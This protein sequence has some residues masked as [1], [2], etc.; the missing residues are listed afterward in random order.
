M[1]NTGRRLRMRRL[2]RHDS[3]RLLIV[4]IDHSVT[5]G[6]VACNTDYER[7]LS[8]LSNAEVD[9]VVLHKGRLRTLKEDFY[10]R[11]SVIVHVSAST[12][13]A[14]DTTEKYL[15]ASVESAVRRGADGISVHVNLGSDTEA[16][17][18]SDLAAV[19]DECDK[20]GVPLLAMLYARGE[21]MRQ[22]PM[23]ETLAH[24]ASLASDLGADLVKL[25][26]P[27]DASAIE[28]ITT[29]CA[30]PVLAA[31][32][33]RLDEASFLDFVATVVHGGGAGLAA[34][35]NIFLADQIGALVRR[36]RLCLNENLPLVRQEARKVRPAR[37]V[38]NEVHHV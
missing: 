11:M 27:N 12:K 20:V 10:R 37:P 32:G 16:Q 38:Q 6:P 13:F 19:A 28:W 1:E 18:L 4:P 34:G 17:Q 7:I 26:L 9:A 29:R 14:S 2:Y 23:M 24:A 5:D 31:G 35:R 22:F 15:V 21:R 25:S 8:D 33:P 36:V 30:V 3:R